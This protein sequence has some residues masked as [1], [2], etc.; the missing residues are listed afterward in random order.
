M[1]ELPRAVGLCPVHADEFYMPDAADGDT[2]PL[3]D[4]T[5]PLVIY[6]R[7]TIAEAMAA[8]IGDDTERL[9]ADA[10]AA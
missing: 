5:R 9:G 3:R 7:G 2:C 8:T 6:R 10:V 1:R 4:C